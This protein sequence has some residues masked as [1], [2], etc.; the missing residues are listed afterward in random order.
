MAARLFFLLTLPTDFIQCVMQMN[1]SELICQ[2]V[3]EAEIFL[4]FFG[5]KSI[6]LTFLLPKCKRFQTVIFL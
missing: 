3:S 5:S 2:V 4:L 6:R 1:T